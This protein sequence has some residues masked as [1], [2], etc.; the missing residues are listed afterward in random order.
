LKYFTEFDT[1]CYGCRDILVAS[2]PC[3]VISRN[4]EIIKA[5]QARQ[6]GRWAF[7]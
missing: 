4:K 6:C 3:Y 5:S 1:S 7:R 2:T